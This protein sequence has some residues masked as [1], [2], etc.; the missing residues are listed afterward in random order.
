[1]KEDEAWTEWEP[2][3]VAPGTLGASHGHGGLKSEA[4]EACISALPCKFITSPQRRGETVPCRGV[5]ALSFEAQVLAIDHQWPFL[6]S[7][8][9]RGGRR[10]CRCL[11]NVKSCHQVFCSASLIS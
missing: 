2:S 1:M 5:E 8:V 9:R 4:S 7:A 6:T 11:V 10:G 3:Y